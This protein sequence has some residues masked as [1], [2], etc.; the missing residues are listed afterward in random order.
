MTSQFAAECLLLTSQLPDYLMGRRKL[1]VPIARRARYVVGAGDSS[2]AKSLSPEGTTEELS[3]WLRQHLVSYEP[4]GERWRIS[5]DEAE[6]CVVVANPR[7]TLNCQG[8]GAPGAAAKAPATPVD[9]L[10]SCVWTGHVGAA[11][12]QHVHISGIGL[13]TRVANPN[14][15][16]AP[17][18]LDAALP[19]DSSA[20]AADDVLAPGGLP[21]LQSA[22]ASAPPPKHSVDLQLVLRGSEDVLHT[23][24]LDQLLYLAA[25]RNYSR[26]V[27]T[28]E[29][30]RVRGALSRLMEWMPGFVV[31]VHRSYAVNA[32]AVRE[33][34]GGNLVLC[35]GQVIRVP[36]R[37]RTEMR[38]AVLRAQ[39]EFADLPRPA[40]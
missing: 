16:V 26:L 38:A 35:D 19:A 37:K 1:A 28:Q 36:D 29:T 40:V 2:A 33:M 24:Q 14:G 27:G 32:L 13:A 15:L 34:H 21:V 25:E 5:L 39:S 11:Q 6:A 7:I 12:L 23:V 9:I 17:D 4:C 10:V 3:D 22:S 31:R 18:A 20:P 30:V 8:G